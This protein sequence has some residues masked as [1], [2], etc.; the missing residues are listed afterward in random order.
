MDVQAYNYC[1]RSSLFTLNYSVMPLLFFVFYTGTKIRHD[2]IGS[3]L[4]S[5]QHY[6]FMRAHFGSPCNY[7]EIV[8]QL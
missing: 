5:K 7:F 3:L 2:N 4:Y 8:P 6:S 1:S